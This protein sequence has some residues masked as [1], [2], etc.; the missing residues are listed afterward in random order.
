MNC[1]ID[2]KIYQEF[3][4]VLNASNVFGCEKE[5]VEFIYDILN[6]WEPSKMK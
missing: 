1:P 2:E 4:K 3:R 6:N 5:Y